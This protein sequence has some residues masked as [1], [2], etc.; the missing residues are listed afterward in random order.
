M[1]HGSSVPRYKVE[2]KNPHKNEYLAALTMQSIPLILTV[3]CKKAY[4][5]RQPEIFP[6]II[7]KYN[8]PSTRMMTA[9]M[10][11]T[12]TLSRKLQGKP[13]SLH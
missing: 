5:L 2:N 3:P 11:A 7:D 9:R 13:V 10:D 4:E 12:I 8:N 1:L 6:V